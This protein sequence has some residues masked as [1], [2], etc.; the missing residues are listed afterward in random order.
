[1]MLP[2]V[3]DETMGKS[4]EARPGSEAGAEPGLSP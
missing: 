2:V 4:A 3:A 1:M